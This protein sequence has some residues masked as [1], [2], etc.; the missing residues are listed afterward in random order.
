MEQSTPAT[1]LIFDRNGTVSEP[2]FTGNDGGGWWW[3]V[4]KGGEVWLENCWSEMIEMTSF[5]V[6][7]LFGGVIRVC[8]NWR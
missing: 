1:L 5:V 6:I 8:K 7:F 2:T 4:V 3:S